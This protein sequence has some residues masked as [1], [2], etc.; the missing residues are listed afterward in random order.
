MYTDIELVLTY[1]WNYRKGKFCDKLCLAEGQLTEME[2]YEA[3]VSEGQVP[4]TNS[5]YSHHSIFLNILLPNAS[6][7]LGLT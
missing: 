4:T 6:L 5:K 2:V 3:K 7:G 1:Y